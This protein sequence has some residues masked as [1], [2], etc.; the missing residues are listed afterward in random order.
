DRSFVSVLAIYFDPRSEESRSRAIAAWNDVKVRA[1]ESGAVPY[2]MGGAASDLMPKM[3]E[4][5]EVLRRLKSA[6]DPR[7]IMSPGILGL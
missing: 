1:L 3:G 5:Y 6:L 4:Y 2:Y 7:G